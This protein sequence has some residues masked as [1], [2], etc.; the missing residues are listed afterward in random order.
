MRWLVCEQSVMSLIPGS[1]PLVEAS[2]SSQVSIDI[3]VCEGAGQQ[4]CLVERGIAHT[5]VTPVD[6][7]GETA[8]AHEEMLRT[9]IGVNER[10]R[11]MHERLHLAEE[12]FRCARQSLSTTGNTSRSNSAHCSWYASTQS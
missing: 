6:H 7:A 9:E 10:R 1:E 5:H 12:S 2:P 4:P 3:P 11:E 8:V